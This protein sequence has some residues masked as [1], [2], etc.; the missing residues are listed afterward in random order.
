M[1]QIIILLIIFASKQWKKYEIMHIISKTTNVNQLEVNL[2]M[3][4]HRIIFHINDINTDNI[5]G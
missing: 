5:I 2:H 4:V 3:K 1:S